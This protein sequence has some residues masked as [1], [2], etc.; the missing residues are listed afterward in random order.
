MKKFWNI[1][2]VISLSLALCI[3]STIVSV[4]LLIIFVISMQL[5]G[6]VDW[7]EEIMKKD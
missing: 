7:M 2:S 6:N 4:I 5:S 3:E 1:L